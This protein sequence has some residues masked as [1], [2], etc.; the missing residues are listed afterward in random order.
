MALL[1]KMT[2]NFRC[3]MCLRHPV[4]WGQ[5]GDGLQFLELW[6]RPN[7]HSRGAKWQNWSESVHRDT[8]SN[9]MSPLDWYFVL[10]GTLSCLTLSCLTL[11]CL[12]LSCLT[13]SCLTLSC[14]TLSCF[15]MSCFMMSLPWSFKSDHHSWERRQKNFRTIN[16]LETFLKQQKADLFE[17]FHNRSF[18]YRKVMQG[19]QA[20]W[21][22]VE[23]RRRGVLIQKKENAPFRGSWVL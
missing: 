7:N 1:R 6:S 21:C 19:V 18:F 13:L 15:M 5:G 11:S 10:L 22:A 2:C 12:T 3:P 4:I 9:C 16:F 20:T 14:L 8:D 23:T 17:F